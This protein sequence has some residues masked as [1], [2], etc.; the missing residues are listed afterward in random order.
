MRLQQCFIV[1]TAY[2]DAGAAKPFGHVLCLE[3]SACRCANSSTCMLTNDNMRDKQ[4]IQVVFAEAF[5]KASKCTK[6]FKSIHLPKHSLHCTANVTRLQES[7]KLAL[8]IYM[9]CLQIL[10]LTSHLLSST[11]FALASSKVP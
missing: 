2:S 6:R 7:K 1:A 9:L 4:L 8:H 10:A 11:A 3:M 5:V